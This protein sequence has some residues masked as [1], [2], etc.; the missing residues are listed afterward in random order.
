MLTKNLTV[1]EMDEAGK[2][3]ALI[4]RLSEI[5]HDGETY[6][7]GAFSWKGDQWCP[8]L[9]AHDRWSMPFGKARVYEDGDTAM[10]ELHLNLETQGGKEWHSALKFDL[11]KGKSVQEWSYGYDVIDADFQVR[12]DDK[13]RVLKRLDVHEVSTVVRG[14]GRGT[15]T[16]SMKGIKAALKEG[17]FKEL[18][19]QL[20]TAAAVVEADPNVLS[21]TGRKQL[22]EIHSSLGVV[23]KLCDPE[24]SAKA[25]AEIESQIVRFE[26][27]EARR[28]IGA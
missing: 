11:A 22:S 20:G 10:A 2:G 18:I 21:E 3:L 13:V 5:D 27:R 26:T 8:L 19:E 1:T 6:E 4:A 7:K 24:A 28:R 12:G 14:A 23:L 15:G 25:I 16:V 9:T 17:Q